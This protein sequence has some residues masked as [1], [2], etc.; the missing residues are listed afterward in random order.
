M[1][2]PVF[3]NWPSNA[4]AD[5]GKKPLLLE[6][7]LH[8]N[9][10]F[11]RDALAELIQRYPVEHYAL[12]HTGRRG[13]SKKLWREGEIGDLTGHQ[14]IDWISAGRMWLNLRNV[15]SVDARYGELLDTIFEEAEGKVPGFKSFNRGM[16]I[17]ISSPDAQVYYHAD[18][19]GQSLWQ[20][21]GSKRLYLYPAEEPYLPQA[22]L[23]R[24]ALYGIEVDMGY[25]P[26]YDREA[27]VVDLQPGQMMT[28]PLNAPHRVEN[29]S[30]LNV[31][32]TTEHWTD[33]IRRE[34]MVSTANGVLRNVFGVTPRSRAIEGPG[35]MAK[36][37]LQAA[38]RRS[39]WLKKERRRRR[40]I[41]FRL[42]RET[43]GGIVDI[44]AYTR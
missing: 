23:E 9:P 1:P 3:K 21:M 11:S 13:E 43:P 35:F 4:S 44:P 6:H 15:K 30:V 29:H 31:S 22:E 18:L 28:W 7:S 37:A 32:V 12:V 27:L 26:V 10:L 33:E 34:Q 14:V 16:G 36:A 38:F 39:P 25:D 19:P 8:E 40:P 20:I 17:L 41:D 24:I 42:A 2:D 5:W